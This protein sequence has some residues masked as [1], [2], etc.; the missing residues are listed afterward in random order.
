MDVAKFRSMVLVVALTAT[1]VLVVVLAWQKHDW[2]VRI[3]GLTTRTR[4]P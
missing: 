2:L 3:E 1:A 4:D